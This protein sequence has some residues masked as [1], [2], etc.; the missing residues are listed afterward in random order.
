MSELIHFMKFHKAYIFPRFQILNRS[1][2]SIYIVCTMYR[3]IIYIYMRSKKLC[4][5]KSQN[6]LYFATEGVVAIVL[7]CLRGFD[8][9][10]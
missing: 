2:F 7:F 8:M 5:L 3:D 6:D 9:G 1:D 10:H 4:T